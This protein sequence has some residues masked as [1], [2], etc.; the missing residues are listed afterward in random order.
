MIYI[1]GNLVYMIDGKV[2]FNL[3]VGYRLGRIYIGII[4]SAV[5]ESHF[6]YSSSLVIST[7]GEIWVL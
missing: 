1:F 2:D 3:I 6:S 4:P 7:P 5:E